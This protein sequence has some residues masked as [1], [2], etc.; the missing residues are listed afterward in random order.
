MIGSGWNPHNS[1]S[2]TETVHH[3]TRCSLPEMGLKVAPLFYTWAAVRIQIEKKDTWSHNPI[4]SGYTPRMVAEDDIQ[5]N[6]Y[7]VEQV[8]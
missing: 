5:F 2:R 3:Y 4:S 6:Y 8:D 1:L 7:L